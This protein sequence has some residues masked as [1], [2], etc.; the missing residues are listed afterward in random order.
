M[1]FEEYYYEDI[2]DN[3][4]TDDFEE[5]KKVIVKEEIIDT[6]PV[7]TPYVYVLSEL[8]EGEIFII[9]NDIYFPNNTHIQRETADK[10]AC[11]GSLRKRGNR[12]VLYINSLVLLCR[13]LIILYMSNYVVPHV[14]NDSNNIPRIVR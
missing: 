2:E 8:N 13:A 9:G 14:Q 4:S 5:Y 3:Y 7:I 1:I 11:Y 10:I 6:S 12:Y